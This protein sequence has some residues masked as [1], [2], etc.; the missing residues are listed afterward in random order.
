MDLG[1][2]PLFAALGRKMAWLTDRQHVL[3]QNVANVDTPH[4]QAQ[5][6]K[7]LDFGKELRQVQSR[8]LPVSTNP[9]H[10]TGTPAQGDFEA[11][12]N[13]KPTERTP[14][15]NSVSLEEEL[16]KVSATANDYNLLTSLYKRQVNMIKT[17]IGH[18]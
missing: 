18:S 13:R 5:D 14:A 8:L 17:A 12:K 10:I 7:P 3:A 2:I 1:S 11:A 16:M 4:Y 15:G 9:M 6:L